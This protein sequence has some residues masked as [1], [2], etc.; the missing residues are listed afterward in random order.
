L[1]LIFTGKNSKVERLGFDQDRIYYG[2]DSD[3]AYEELIG[4]K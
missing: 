4:K 1:Q 3:H 2:I